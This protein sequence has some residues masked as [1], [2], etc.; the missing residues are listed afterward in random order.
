M[1]TKQQKDLINK[2]AIYLC[3]ELD[4]LTWNA[5]ATKL[6]DDCTKSE[7]EHRSGFCYGREYPKG[8]TAPLA[9]RY[10]AIRYMAEFL[11]RV[12]RPEIK[13][14]IHLKKE[15]VYAA[16]VYENYTQ[17]VKNAI[18]G[19]V[20]EI[21][22]LD[23]VK[24]V[25]LEEDAIPREIREELEILDITI[26]KVKKGNASDDLKQELITGYEKEKEELHRKLNEQ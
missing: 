8:F 18:G 25:E 24:L 9:G 17:E 16:S 20:P 14:L 19:L 13:D 10:Q 21:L 26:E 12:P 2:A 11:S 15:Y 3:R 22:E 5:Y 4:Y 6:I 23:Y 7:R 1:I